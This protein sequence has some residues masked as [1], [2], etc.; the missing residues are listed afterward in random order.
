MHNFTLHCTNAV[1]HDTCSQKTVCESHLQN[2]FV[3]VEQRWSQQSRWFM[4]VDY[5]TR[6]FSIHHGKC[7]IMQLRKV[8]QKLLF[9]LLT[10]ALLHAVS[11]SQLCC[12]VCWVFV[13]WFVY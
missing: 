11:N 13:K 4:L 2:S 7:K 12:L 10:S 9:P 3:I 1:T 6:S 8:Y 5:V